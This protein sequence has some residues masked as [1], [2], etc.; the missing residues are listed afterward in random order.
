L[1]KSLRDDYER[2]NELWRKEH[3]LT[4]NGGPIS[5]TE[6][7]EMEMLNVRIADRTRA[8]SCPASYGQIEAHR[9]SKRLHKLFCKRISPRSCGGGFLTAAEDVEEAQLR[10]RVLAFEES[11]EGLA[12]ARIFKLTLM[13]IGGVGRSAAEQ[14]EFDRL[15]AMYP[16]KTDPDDP[17]KEQ[18]D[19]THRA[20]V[21][22]IAREKAR[23]SHIRNSR[24]PR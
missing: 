22:A 11:P 17:L 19:A 6:L 7:K 16:Y 8:I 24:P 4:E 3:A 21:A 15:Q 20:I 13:G 1:A 9:D 12:L 14:E 18:S 2:L 23:L 10:A 5:A